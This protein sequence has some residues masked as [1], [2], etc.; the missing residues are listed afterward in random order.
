MSL[1][2]YGSTGFLLPYVSSLFSL[3]MLRK[4]PAQSHSFWRLV[5]WG[6]ASHLPPLSVFTVT[7]SSAKNSLV[8]LHP[9]ISTFLTGWSSPSQADIQGSWQLSAT[10]LSH[11]GLCGNRLKDLF[12]PKSPSVCLWSR[13]LCLQ[14]LLIC[15][16]FFKGH[17]KPHVLHVATTYLFNKEH[18]LSPLSS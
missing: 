9:A 5:L 8:N 1:H 6:V 15:S 3:H 4:V 7:D 18:T 16:P 14:N 2:Q 10:V 17:L 13:C 11:F 12:F